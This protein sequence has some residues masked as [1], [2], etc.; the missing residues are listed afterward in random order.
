MDKNLTPDIETENLYKT[1]FEKNPSCMYIFDKETYAILDIN[2][3]TLNTYGYTREEFLNMSINDFRPSEDIEKAQDAVL[4]LHSE[5][6]T[7][8]WRH[9]KKNGELITVEI[10]AVEIMYKGRKAILS[11]PQDITERVKKEEEINKLNANLI[12]LNEELKN[13]ETRLKA[14][15][16]AGKIG[17]WEYDFKEELYF[18][19][20]EL[21]KIFGIP[22]RAGPVKR[23][24][25]TPTVHPDDL[26]IVRGAVERA[27]LYGEFS[28]YTYRI[29]EPNGGI[30]YIYTKGEVIKDKNGNPE[31]IFGV[32]MDITEREKD[33]QEL[34]RHS[35]NIDIIL[36]SI[37][38]IFYIVDKDYSILFAN[39]AVEKLTG[40]TKDELLGKN[41]WEIFHD[42]NLSLPKEYFEKSLKENKAAQFDMDY[43]GIIFRVFI[44]PSELGL[45]VSG[46]DVTE[47]VRTQEELSQQLNNINIILASITDPF[48]II[49]SSYN[50]IFANSALAELTGNK[51][52]NLIGKKLWPIFIQHNEDFTNLRRGL[53]KSLKD[54][55]TTE[56]EFSFNERTFYTHVYPSE[57]G[58][59]VSCSDITTKKK[60][61]YELKLNTKFLKEISDSL[62]GIIF[63]SEFD[64]DLNP[65]LNYISAKV[66]EFTGYTAEELMEDYS[67]HLNSIHKDDLEKF[68]ISRENVY[69]L[70][71]MTMKYRYVN[72]KT[73][74]IRWVTVTIVPSRLSSGNIIRNGILLDVTESEKY[75]TELE[76]SNQRYE[77]VSKAANETIWDLDLTTNIMTLG[78]SYK[79]MYGSSYPDDKCD[80]SELRKLVHPDDIERIEKSIIAVM[81]DNSKQYWEDYYRVYKEDGSLIYVHDRGYIIYNEKGVPVRMVGTNQDITALKMA[82]K[83]REEIIADLEKSNQR[84]EYISKASN[85][86]IWDMDVKSSI[87]TMGGSYK[88]MYGTSFPDNQ[89]NVYEAEKFLHP[90]DFPVM[91]EKMADVISR[92]ENY[93]EQHYRICRPDG[94]IIYVYE[95]GYIF[96]EEE[97]NIPIRILGTMQD[98]TA[99]KLA[100]LEREKIISDLEKSNLRYEYIS[101][102]AKE[103]IWEID[104]INEEI[105]FGGDYENMYGFSLPDKKSK[106]KSLLLELHPDDAERV[107]SEQK[108]VLINKETHWESQYRLVKPDRSVI[109]VVEKAFIIYD[110]KTKQPL[111][112]IGVTQDISQLKKSEIERERM[113]MDLMRRNKALEQFTYM[114]SHNIRAP[115]SNI[116]GLSSILEDKSYDSETKRDLIPMLLASSNRLDEVV[117]DMNDILN[118]AKDLEEEKTEVNF[119]KILDEILNADERAIKKSKIK[120]ISDFEKVNSIY[121]VKS[122]VQSVF[123]NL[124]E[125]S[126]K[127]RSEDS[128][129]LNISSSEDN[130]FIYLTFEDNGIGFDSKKNKEKVF[131]LYNRFHHE[132]EG[133]GMGLFIVKKHIENLDGEITVES[134]VN[135]G[136]KFLIKLKKNL[137]I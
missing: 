103:T 88:E 56:L 131:Q 44:Y 132:K 68:K 49:D 114:V 105:T 75:Y 119:N 31:K 99:L 112:I 21:F 60:A 87:L 84:Y 38:D 83:E 133:K 30:K 58:L 109:Y 59:A 9:I 34:L 113:I 71:T 6:K 101:K 73:Q 52:E 3:T 2:E 8:I 22:F 129:Y 135:K 50:F 20:E 97:T 81:M 12:L 77:Y 115:L 18:I 95:R 45:A 54:K 137:H 125:N 14:A 61:E 82:E 53:E 120:V 80:I 110:K 100:E 118:I 42:A 25:L 17:Y 13:N 85:E 36:R 64:K 23:E 89:I 65:K 102:A 28:D 107:K 48:F 66:E 90:D 98:V 24:M 122:A 69:S 128:P 124:I 32:S 72:R 11:I 117:R 4:N 40:L 41:V 33:R 116:L 111:N 15:Q 37:T 91:L 43:H 16:E 29:P 92:R 86:T 134:E 51:I 94:S 7:G 106:L 108:N 57:I 46:K 5:F 70:E 136:T 67:R 121:A 26:H 104:L 35:N 62:P 130:E 63:Q 78:G 1:L 55:T 74:E 27:M 19:S 126:I 79:K 96:Y 127:F 93:L 76:K 123:K 39:E 10:R 47:H